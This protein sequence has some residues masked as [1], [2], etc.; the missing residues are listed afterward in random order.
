ML[1]ARRLLSTSHG[2][3][4]RRRV[5]ARRPCVRVRTGDT[6]NVLT[7]DALH[8]S[9][10]N[11]LQRLSDLPSED[12]ARHAGALLGAIERDLGVER[13]LLT[14][15]NI[16]VPGLSGVDPLATLQQGEME[17]LLTQLR[18]TGKPDELRWATALVELRLQ[19]DTAFVAVDL[20]LTDRA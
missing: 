3:S 1:L 19:L 18:A 13:R 14:D 2:A 10:D 5:V 8:E 17:R 16:G 12:R 7:I 20:A 15:L 9:M 11:S 6:T 4:A